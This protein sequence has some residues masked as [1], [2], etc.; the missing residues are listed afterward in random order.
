VRV[1]GTENFLTLTQ[2]ERVDSPEGLRVKDTKFIPPATAS[3]VP[4]VVFKGGPEAPVENLVPCLDTTATDNPFLYFETLE[5]STLRADELVSGEYVNVDG[6]ISRVLYGENIKGCSPEHNAFFKVGHKVYVFR[7][8][9]NG[10]ASFHHAEIDNCPLVADFRFFEPGHVQFQCSPTDTVLYDP[11]NSGDVVERLDLTVN[12][13][14]FQCQEANLNIRHFEGNLTVSVYGSD[15]EDDSESVS[16]LPFNDTTTGKCVGGQSPVLFL[17]RSNGETYFLD[18][19]T[20]KLH[21]LAS[22]T[23]GPHS[24]LELSVLHTESGLVVGVFDYSTNDYLVLNLACPSSPAVSRV[25]YNS[26]PAR[27]TL[28]ASGT[29]QQCPPCNERD[30]PSASSTP[31]TPSGGSATGPDVTSP[32]EPSIATPDQGNNLAAATDSGTLIGVSIGVIV[33]VVLAAALVILSI[34]AL[35]WFQKSKRSSSSSSSTG[36]SDVTAGACREGE[37]DS[38]TGVSGES[39][40]SSAVESIPVL[41]IGE[42]VVDAVAVS[43]S[44]ADDPGEQMVMVATG[45]TADRTRFTPGEVRDNYDERTE[46]EQ[47]CNDMEHKMWN[48]E[49]AL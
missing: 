17:A 21:F 25:H 31:L 22:D 29:T 20:G 23:C 38:A 7:V 2:F 13:S 27:V 37:I 16:I 47:D 11:C 41:P 39:D 46:R 35:V 18:L 15:A 8:F 5:D 36:E 10:E 34:V 48:M 3:C 42:D 28:A 30:I 32:D 33:T 40:A 12:A 9:V 24:C 1:N 14:V 49:S 4:L 6:D 26:P 45:N 43:P 44:E 19:S